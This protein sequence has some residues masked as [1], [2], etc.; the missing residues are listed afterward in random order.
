MRAYEERIAAQKKAW[1][2]LRAIGLKISDVG[3]YPK[4]KHS[5]EGVE[6]DIS[7]SDTARLYGGGEWFVVGSDYIWYV[8]NNGHDGD[9]WACNNVLTGGAGAVGCR[10]DFDQEVADEIKTLYSIWKS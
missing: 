2:S 6:Y 4:G 7:L 9:Y 3:E 1:D 10:I 5:P 8:V